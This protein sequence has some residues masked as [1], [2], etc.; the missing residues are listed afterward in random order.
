MDAKGEVKVLEGDGVGGK[1]GELIGEL[2]KRGEVLL[3][4]DVEGIRVFKVDGDLQDVSVEAMTVQEFK[5][6]P[7]GAWGGSPR[8]LWQ[9]AYLGESR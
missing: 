9:K 4:R 1:T 2:G 7:R 8:W 6:Q 3:Q 5:E